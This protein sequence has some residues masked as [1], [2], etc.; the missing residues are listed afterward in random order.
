MIWL[1]SYGLVKLQKVREELGEEGLDRMR[2]LV[3]LELAEGIYYGDS[4]IFRYIS[5]KGEK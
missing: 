2:D 3:S 5:M 4:Y 1:K